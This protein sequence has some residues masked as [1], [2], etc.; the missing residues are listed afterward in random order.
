M[1]PPPPA[2]ASH[3]PNRCSM[4]LPASSQLECGWLL[5]ITHTITHACFGRLDTQ[6]LRKRPGDFPPPDTDTIPK[7]NTRCSCLRLSAA[8]YGI[9]CYFLYCK[10]QVVQWQMGNLPLHWQIRW[11]IL[12]ITHAMVIGNFF[13]YSDSHDFWLTMQDTVNLEH[14]LPVYNNSC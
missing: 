11:Q 5:D 13:Y 1:G 14:F 4:F 3:W 10:I 7:S 2:L 8:A 6:D 9:S 12:K